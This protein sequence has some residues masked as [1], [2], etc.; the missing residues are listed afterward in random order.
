MIFAKDINNDQES[1]ANIIFRNHTLNQYCTDE[2]KK[3]I[4]DNLSCRN[5]HK[6]ELIFYEGQPS[7]LIY[8]ISHG[9]VKLWKEG[10]HNFEQVIRFSK[11]GDMMGFWGSLENKNYTL[12][13]T[14]IMDSQLYHIRKDVFLPVIEQNSSLIVF[15]HDYIKDLKK[16]E[17]DL[18]NMAE[19]NVREK[20]AHSILELLDLFKNKVDENAYKIVLSRKEISSLSAVSEDRIT[21]QLSDF[22]KENI[23]KT[24]GEKI[25][26]DQKKLQE[27]IRPYLV[28]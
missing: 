3:I 1:K 21:K 26:I 14:A 18:R 23:I 20:V 19:M 22:K 4:I 16:T 15:L 5:Y 17:E 11:E 24:D 25:F 2:Q 28:G 13:A 9:L 27:I 7:Y 6:G 10:L 12:S 8:F